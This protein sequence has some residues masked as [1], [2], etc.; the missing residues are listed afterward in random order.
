M[1][2]SCSLLFYKTPNTIVLQATKPGGRFVIVGHGPSKVEFPVV[3]LVAK[4]IE[5]V[6]S[7]RYINTYVSSCSCI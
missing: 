6:G 5:I 3:N 1:F 2:K 7:F 4:E